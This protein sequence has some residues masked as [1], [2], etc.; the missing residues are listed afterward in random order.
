MFKKVKN[1]VLLSSFTLLLAF[2]SFS[3]K[4]VNAQDGIDCEQ[5]GDF[6]LETFYC[7][8]MGGETKCIAN[9]KVEK[10]EQ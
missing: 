7:P 4:T 6:I 3:S 8:L 5:E 10:N 2:L 1:L 9:C